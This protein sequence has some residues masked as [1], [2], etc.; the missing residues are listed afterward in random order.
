MYYLRSF[1]EGVADSDPYLDL[2]LALADAFDMLRTGSRL[3]LWIRK[4]D[5][6]VMNAMDIKRAYK[7]GNRRV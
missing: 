4:D 5:D 7:N 1:Y 2:E 6:I 3:P